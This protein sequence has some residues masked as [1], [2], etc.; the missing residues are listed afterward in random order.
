MTNHRTV[1]AVGNDPSV[2]HAL[3]TLNG[4]G[5]FDS[6]SDTA[7]W[8]PILKSL[9]LHPAK[10]VRE[11]VLKAM[12]L[13][14]ASAEAIKAQCTANDSDPQVRLQAFLALA[15]M[16]AAPSGPVPV[17]NTY[18]TIAGTDTYAN[19]AFMKA[20]TGNR[21]MTV[22]TAPTGCPTLAA[23]TPVFSAYSNYQALPKDDFRLSFARWRRHRRTRRTEPSNGP[24]PAPRAPRRPPRARSAPSSPSATR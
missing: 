12:P 20:N 11:N 10:G 22:M 14:T 23:T 24:T 6:T 4:L 21:V 9:L 3:W 19:Q 7:R 2:M 1:D 5:R 18:T 8:N 16:P 15:A 13:T 17:L